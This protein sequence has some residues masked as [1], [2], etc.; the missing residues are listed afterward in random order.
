M[1]GATPK[2][3]LKG[4]VHLNTRREGEAQ[5]AVDDSAVFLHLPS[6]QGRRRWKLLDSVTSDCGGLD[7]GRLESSASA[8]VTAVSAL[9]CHPA[10]WRASPDFDL[11]KGSAAACVTFTRPLF[12][13][14]TISLYHCSS[15]PV[16]TLLTHDAFTQ[17]PTQPHFHCDSPLLKPHCA[18]SQPASSPAHTTPPPLPHLP[19]STATGAISV[20]S[21]S[22]ATPASSPLPHAPQHTSPS[23]PP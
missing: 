10:V 1:Q 18:L 21:T 13:R 6:M 20:I 7:A 11:L 3:T 12:R 15:T 17:R 8:S 22:S 4:A 19:L 14:L 16:P 5:Q 2:V 9:S 23:L